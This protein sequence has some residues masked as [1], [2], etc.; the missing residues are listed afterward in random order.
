MSIF[1]ELKKDPKRRDLLEFGLIFGGGMG[2]IGAFNY[3]ALHVAF[4]TGKPDRALPLWIIGGAILVLSQI[5]VLG[6][7]LYILWMGL[8]LVIGFF[9]APVIMFIVYSVVILPVGLI[10]KLTKRDTMRRGLDPKAPSYW[11]DYPGSDD[12]ASYVRQF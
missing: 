8:G 1:K 9:T 10:F 4:I 7:W 5:P 2:L 11:E 3:F 12:P 6:R